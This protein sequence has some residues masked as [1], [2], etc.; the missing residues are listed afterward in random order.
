MSG[1]KPLPGADGGIRRESAL[2]SFEMWWWFRR[3]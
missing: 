2:D 1:A 3:R